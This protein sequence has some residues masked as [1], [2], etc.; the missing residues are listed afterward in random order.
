MHNKV[1]KLSDAPFEDGDLGIS[2]DIE[3]TWFVRE[4]CDWYDVKKNVSELELEYSDLARSMCHLERDDHGPYIV[5]ARED[6]DLIN[7][8]CAKQMA[9]F[10]RDLKKKTMDE[11]YFQLFLRNDLSINNDITM[12]R[13]IWFGEKFGDYII[14]DDE[15]LPV[16]V[17]IR[18][19]VPDKPYYLHKDVIDYHW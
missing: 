10:I 18:N 1:F 4:I 13:D 5:F 16:D 12:I 17:F 8:G 15:I 14:Y 9:M 7:K 6:L 2:Y 3:E 11:D 19:A